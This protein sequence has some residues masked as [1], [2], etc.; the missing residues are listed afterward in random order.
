MAELKRVWLRIWA[1]LQEAS[2]E[3]DYDH[4]LVWTQRAGLT[5]VSRDEF[6]LTQIEARYS[7]PNR[8]C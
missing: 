4:Y 5:P 3:R 1:Y 2:G 8:C 7:R 6:F